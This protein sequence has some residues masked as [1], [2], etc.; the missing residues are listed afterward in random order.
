MTGARSS[1]KEAIDFNL[2]TRT[3]AVYAVYWVEVLDILNN[4]NKEAV[5]T[6]QLRALDES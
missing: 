5:F 2:V 3:K 6:I 1:E 4:D